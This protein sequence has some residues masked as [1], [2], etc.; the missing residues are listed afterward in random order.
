MVTP[1]F[2]QIVAISITAFFV[3]ALAID[4]PSF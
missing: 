1:P 3:L 2:I 4:A